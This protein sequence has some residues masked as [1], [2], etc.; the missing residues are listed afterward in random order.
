ME[1]RIP[2]RRHVGGKIW[3]GG[4]R[5]AAT[6]AEKYGEADSD[7]PPCGRKIW[8]GGFRSAAVWAEKYGEADSDPPPLW[9]ADRA[10]W[11]PRHDGA[12][13]PRFSPQGVGSYDLRR[14][15]RIGIR[16]SIGCHGARRPQMWRRI[17]IRLSIGCHGARCPQTVAA[18]RNPP[19]HRVP[20]SPV[21]S[22]VA[23]DWNPPFHGGFLHILGFVRVILMGIFSV[24]CAFFAYRFGS[25][26]K[27]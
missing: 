9:V 20:R 2:I 8:K 22:D 23:A 4:F 21:S 15:R 11:R 12:Q 7:P 5:S 13:A 10:S 27:F 14:W 24:F 25:F 6:W 18:D 1:R 3:R 26:R 19:F 16:L 17:G